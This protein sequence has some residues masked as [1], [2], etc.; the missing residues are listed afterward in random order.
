MGIVD[1]STPGSTASSFIGQAGGTQGA[2]GLITQAT[3]LI[4][5]GNIFINTIN[6]LVSTISNLRGSSDNIITSDT[7]AKIAKSKTTPP[8]GASQGPS[9]QDLAN[10]FQTPEG[11]MKIGQAID[12]MIPLTGDI[13]L[14]Q[15]KNILNTLN[16]TEQKPKKDKKK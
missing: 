8:A 4:K 16:A 2:I 14:S 12:Q 13:K 1:I 7:S 6:Q 9:D 5:E 15:V 10:F 11:I 3:T